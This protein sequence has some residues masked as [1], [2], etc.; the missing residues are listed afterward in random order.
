M[1]DTLAPKMILNTKR[2]GRRG[3]GRPKLR[4]L[5]EVEADTKTIG[6]KRWKLN[7][8]DRKEWTVILREATAKLKGP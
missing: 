5:D 7:A 8:Q 4:C 6:M 1:E 3:V 2:E